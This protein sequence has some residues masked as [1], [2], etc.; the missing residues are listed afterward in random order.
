MDGVPE[1]A[2]YLES[3]AAWREA[4]RPARVRTLLVAES[5]V[6]ECPGDSAAR[7]SPAS[8]LPDRVSQRLPRSFCRLVYCLGYGESTIC[9]PPPTA[10]AGTW[11]YWDILGQAAGGMG[12]IQPRKSRTDAIARLTWKLDA[13]CAL[14][15]AGVWLVDAS[16]MALYAPGGR[17]LFAGARYER[18]IRES[19]SRFVWP[20]VVHE[21]IEQAWVIGRGVWGAL[22]NLPEL[23]AARVISQPQDRDTERYR[24][25]LVGM[26]SEIHRR[27]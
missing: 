13:L 24:A 21:P 20:T 19:W 10:N 27:G 5:H 15:D 8:V 6:A 11:Q 26:V 14:Q 7:V 23:A 12:C 9:H 25:E 1:S 22:G 2:A 16:I 17:R 18:T 4:W 3:V